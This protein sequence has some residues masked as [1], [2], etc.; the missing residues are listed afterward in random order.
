MKRTPAISGP[1]AVRNAIEFG[2]DPLGFLDALRGGG[3]GTVLPRFVVGPTLH[4]VLDDSLVRE[5]L[6]TN[7][8]KYHRPDILSSLTDA[9][10]RNGL[11]QSDGALWRAQRSRLQPLFGRDRIIEYCDAIGAVTEDV[12]G[13]WLEGRSFLDDSS[14]GSDSTIRSEERRTHEG[15][16][17]SRSAPPS[18]PDGSASLRVNLYEEMVGLTARVIART[19]LDR[20]ITPAETTFGAGPQACVGGQMALAEAQLVLAAIVAQFDLDIDARRLDDLR[21]AGVLQLRGGMPAV[22]TP[23]TE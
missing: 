10:T 7:H 5:V 3:V 23:T 8:D 6:L 13:H 17:G 22:V 4:I 16:R 11:I 15:I 12:T 20:T 9:L 14:V 19:L 2:R 21:P 1:G 18:S